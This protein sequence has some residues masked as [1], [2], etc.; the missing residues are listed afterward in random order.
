[1]HKSPLLYSEN[2]NQKD[3]IRFPSEVFLEKIETVKNLEK[4]GA[5]ISATLKYELDRILVAKR[6]H[7]SGFLRF[8]EGR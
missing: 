4:E 7:D 1:M 5:E 6:L 8:S 2:R 3:W